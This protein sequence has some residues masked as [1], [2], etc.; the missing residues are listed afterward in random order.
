MLMRLK[1]VLSVLFRG[2]LILLGLAAAAVGAA[3]FSVGADLART[4][5]HKGS[6]VAITAD[7][8]VI[9]EGQRLARIRGCFGGC[10]GR[11]VNGEV[12]AEL[13]GGSRLTAPNLRAAVDRYTTAELDG[14]VRHGIRPDGT[15]LIAVMPSSMFYNLS[16]DDFSAILSFIMTQPASDDELPGTRLGAITR[17]LLV[18]LRHT[19]GTLLAAEEIDHDAPRI[20]PT[21]DGRPNGEYLARTVCTECHGHDLRGA[22][23]ETAPTLAIV[24]AYS[25]ENFETLMRTGVPV[26]GRELDLM[27]AVAESRFAYFTDDEIESLHAYLLTLAAS[28]PGPQS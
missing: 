17:V 1:K 8:D 14:L 10:H 16:D 22:P 5:E 15:S 9:A 6:P 13:P 26:G 21:L 3:W 4:F 19:Y 27:A 24:A 2:L 12:F 28:A 25:L 18:L 11:T 20:P 7:P 23:D